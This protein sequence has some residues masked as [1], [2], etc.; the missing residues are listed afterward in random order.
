MSGIF[1]DELPSK[2]DI[3]QRIAKRFND[4]IS[5]SENSKSLFPVCSICDTFIIV[6]SKV[7]LVS[8]KRM[9][10]M[11]EHLCWR[12]I[13]DCRRTVDIENF[14]SFQKETLG[15]EEIGEDLSFLDGMALS[16]RGSFQCCIGRRGHSGF[17]V[18]ARCFSCCRRKKIPRHAIVNKNYCGVPPVSSGFE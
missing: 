13:E 3:S 9:K 5:L 12:N 16:P 2:F 10:E 11:K 6:K 17:T 7:H 15:E 14:Y 4:V 1:V 8:V 18:C